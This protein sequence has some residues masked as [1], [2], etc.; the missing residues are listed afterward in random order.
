MREFRPKKANATF[1]SSAKVM[2]PDQT[3]A[4][5]WDIKYEGP[6]TVVSQSLR[7]VYKL[8]NEMKDLLPTVYN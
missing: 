5:K 6:F 8:K 3:Q 4:S 1:E 7:G 2:V